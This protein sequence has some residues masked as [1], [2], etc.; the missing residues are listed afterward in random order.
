MLTERV[1]RIGQTLEWI[2]GTMRVLV[3]PLPFVGR[4]GRRP[5][6]GSRTNGAA[7]PVAYE[8]ARSLDLLNS[9][10]RLMLSPSKEV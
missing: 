2:T 5:G 10:R 4:G 1:S 9:V 3:H 6:E 7:P 8:V